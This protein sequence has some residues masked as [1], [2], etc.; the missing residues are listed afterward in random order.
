MSPTVGAAIA[1]AVARLAASGV[2]A[3]DR[4]ARL[5][6]AAAL[7]EPAARLTLALGE[8]LPSAA[9]TA[10]EA[11]VAERA[12]RRPMAQILGRR[13]F[14]GRE[15][16]VTSDVLDP[17]PETETLVA[18]ALAGPAPARVLDLGVGSGAILLTLLAEWPAAHGTGTDASPL[19]LAVAAR[20]A[21]RLGVTGRAMFFPADW[22]DEVAG[23]FDLV[24][25]NPPYVP[26]AAVDGLDPEVRDWEPRMALTPGP[27]GLEAHARI[28][29]ALA[30]L[31]A[32]G[33]RALVEIGAG[34]GAAAGALFRDAGF[35][36]ATHADFDGRARVIEAASAPPRG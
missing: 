11:R 26:A 28:A 15:F 12:R 23:R 35:A 30:A 17:R 6:M 18:A 24:V 27:T 16:E 13:A 20:N 4:D 33:G 21:A 1:G 22:G 3:P 19:A 7:G 2:P 8:P 29:A 5:L 31:L 9:A 25:S 34:Q 10:F 14:W 32:P 36:V